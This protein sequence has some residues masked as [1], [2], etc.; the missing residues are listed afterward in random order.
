MRL[1]ATLS[2]DLD[3][4]WSYMMVH[5]DPQWDQ[6]PSY[7]DV[8]VPRVLS[9]MRKHRLK[10]TVFVVGQDAALE[11]NREALGT[12]AGDG[13]EIGNH[14]FHHRPWLH[15]RS[16]A[17]IDEELARAEEAIEKATA[18][19]PTGFRG[20]GYSRSPVILEVLAERGYSYDASPLST[21]I[22]PLARAYYLHTAKL[23]QEASEQ[24]DELFGQFRDGFGPNR[25]FIARTAS[26][27]LA[28]VPVTTM[29]LFRIP[30]H[31]SYV[32]YL[33]AISPA[34]ARSYVRFT[35]MMCR[36]TK[37]EP[38]ILLHPLDFIGAN[39]APELSFFPGMQLSGDDK[40]ETLDDVITVLSDSFAVMRLS[41]YVLQ[42]RSTTDSVPF[43]V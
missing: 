28:V 36:L 18:C 19:C 11:C 3:N 26:G 43:R 14:S 8:V 37:T 6:F 21:W 23:D 34:L 31:V 40:R 1:N 33:R 7:F 41:D 12:I 38:S 30:I 24:R 20:P 4:K 32:L 22:G 9:T 29:P 2:L 42:L 27:P 13:H 5:G 25:P 10:I 17:E 35:A 39:E 16:R 15:K